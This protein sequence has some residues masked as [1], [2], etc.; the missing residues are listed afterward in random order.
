MNETTE[1]HD[2][3][4]LRRRMVEDQLRRRGISDERLLDVMGKVPRHFFVPEGQRVHAYEDRPLPIGSSQTISQPYMV[5][6]MTELLSLARDSRVLEIGT[7]SGYQAAILAELAGE[8][9]TVERLPD[10]KTRAEALLR[11]L[12]YNN[13]NAVVGD[14]TLGWS[15]KAPYDAI[16]VTAG[17]PR[18]P[19]ELRRQLATDGRMVIPVSAGPS[20][21]LFLVERL[22]QEEPPQSDSDPQKQ[23]DRY[24][25]TA[26]L[27][28]VF[29]PLIGRDGYDS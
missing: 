16:V 11:R 22:E 15:Q 7:G 9:T 21:T 27:G 14:G 4:V 5:A 18:V 29:V 28:C 24:R 12:G 13:V 26:I 6:R 23:Q 17:A 1:E 25:E 3:A 10:L 19:D 20:Q 2:Y 8:V